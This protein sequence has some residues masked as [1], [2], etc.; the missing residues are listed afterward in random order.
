MHL[1]LLIAS[2]KLLIL[3]ATH[4]TLPQN[5]AEWTASGTWRN[6]YILGQAV[7]PISY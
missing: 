7:Q 2:R 1:E 3:W 4:L 6:R 5:L